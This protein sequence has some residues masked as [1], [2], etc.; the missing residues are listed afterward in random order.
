MLGDKSKNFGEIQKRDD[1]WWWWE[2]E[3]IWIYFEDRVF[4][5]IGWINVKYDSMIEGNKEWLEGFW[6]QLHGRIKLPST[7]I[8]L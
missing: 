7:E 8:R 2:L 5:N 4:K 1:Q 3:E 6:S